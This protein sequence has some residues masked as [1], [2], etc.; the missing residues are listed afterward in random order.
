MYFKKGA[1]FKTGETNMKT[2]TAIRAV[3]MIALLCV[4]E[5]VQG[6]EWKLVRF[7]YSSGWDALPAIVAI[8]RGFFAKEQLVVSGLTATSAD[9]VANS[10]ANGSTDVAALPQRTLL[11]LAAIQ[12]PIRIVSMNHWGTEMEL[13]VPPGQ[14]KVASLADLKGKTIAV[15][16]SSE[17]YPALIRLLN[18]A[19]LRPTDVTIK[20]LP[21]E[22]LTQAFQQKNRLADAVFES[23]HFTSV[24]QKTSQA[25]VVLS[26]HDVT[27]KLGYIGASPLV[28]RQELIEKEPKTVQQFVKGWVKA[29]HYIQQDPEDAARLLMIFFHRQGVKAVSEE[30][31][32]SW[33]AM[34]RYDR[35]IWTT[36]DITDAEYNGWGL[37]EG[38]LLKAAPKLSDL[39]ENQF[40]RVAMDSLEA[41]PRA[42]APSGKP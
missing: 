21:A 16:K 1:G 31:T 35:F 17:A 15:G 4:A 23:R 27:E 13:V 38:G 37:K 30:M 40:A 24:L 22:T 34:N 18:K 41:A 42:K 32:K 12:L 8:E 3:L 19:K 5:S 36:A 33:V 14:E 26:A 2:M 10:L 25:R 20:D 6:E 29:L 11:A 28:V 39:V 7:S 9:A